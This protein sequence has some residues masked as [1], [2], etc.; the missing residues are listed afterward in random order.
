MDVTRTKSTLKIVYDTD[1]ITKDHEILPEIIEGALRA[2]AQYLV[3][4]GLITGILPALLD[5]SSISA[6]FKNQ[7]QDDAE[8][9]LHCDLEI[10][11]AFIC[12]G[13]VGN[14]EPF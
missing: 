14:G 3:D 13:S 7:E 10:D 6:K 9:T 2:G 4:E 8:N 1:G 5:S 11:A 12:H